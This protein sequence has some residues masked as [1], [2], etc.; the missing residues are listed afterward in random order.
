MAIFKR[1]KATTADPQW[2]YQFIGGTSAAGVDVTVESAMKS[3][4]VWACV[5]ILAET[6]ASLPLIT[7]E[8]L[9]EGKERAFD[10]HLYPLLHDTPNPYMTAFTFWETAVAH[11]ATWGNFYAE[12][13]MNGQGQVIALWPLTP[14]RVSI[15]LKSGTWE[16]NY[17]VSMSTGGD[18]VLPSERVFHVPGLGFDG[19]KGYSPISMQMNAIGT[20]QAMDIYEASFYKNDATPRTLLVYPGQIDDEMETNIRASWEKQYGGVSNAGKI[21]ILEEGLKV[22]QLG[23]PPADA[24]FLESKKFQVEEIA[25]MSRIPLHLIQHQEKSTAW[26]TGIEQMNIGFVIHTIRPWLVR[27]EKAAQQQLIPERDKRKYFSEFLVDG[28]LRGDMKSRYDA[29][30]IAREKGWM[31]A[32]EIRALEN[33]NP[34]PGGQGKVYLYPMNLAPLG[35]A[36]EEE[37][38]SRVEKREYTKVVQPR[39]NLMR[40]YHGLFKEAASRVVKRE[41][42]DLIKLAKKVIPKNGHEEFRAQYEQ[43]YKDFEPVVRELMLPVFTSYTE[44]VQAAAAREVGGFV[45][46]TPVIEECALVHLDNFARHHCNM[47]QKDLREAMNLK[48]AVPMSEEDYLAGVLAAISSWEEVP[49]EIAEWETVRHNNLIAKAVYHTNGVRNIGW[50]PE[51]YNVHELYDLCVEFGALEVELG[52]DC[53]SA[54]GSF[55][56]KYMAQEKLHRSAGTY[57]PSWPVST[58]PLWPGC[59]CMICALED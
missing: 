12:K 38:R 43:Y 54:H 48:R 18:I 25:R 58:P 35:Q 11:L 44:T 30:A 24:Q 14:S 31:N 52:E 27:I 9:K 42:N 59:K 34:L 17:K 20:L 1:K 36:P 41:M 13:E 45:G 4:T 47:A 26:G 39:A 50:V 46:V 53:R 56:D 32:D 37:G 23:L 57:R 29:Y 40:S 55:W 49:Q 10:Y 19:I 22:E 2:L 33:L 51:P 21:G 5:R 3:S 15:D 28:L 8:R 6:V 7:Y 16:R